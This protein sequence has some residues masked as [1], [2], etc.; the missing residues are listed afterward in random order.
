MISESAFTSEDKIFKS[1]EELEQ[2]G[3][4]RAG[5]NKKNGCSTKLEIKGAAVWAPPFSL[6]I[7]NGEQSLLIDN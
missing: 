3:H 5:T 4:L 6:F 7:F 1:N 2:K